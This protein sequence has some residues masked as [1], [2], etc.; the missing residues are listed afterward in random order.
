MRKSKRER[1]KL[2]RN[3]ILCIALVGLVGYAIYHFYKKKCMAEEHSFNVTQILVPK[4]GML[5]QGSARLCWD[6]SGVAMLEAE[7]IRKGIKDVDLSEAFIA[8]YNSL[9]FAMKAVEDKDVLW[10]L[11]GCM[12]DVWYCLDKYG[13]VP[14]SAMPY[15]DDANYNL[16]NAELSGGKGL[17]HQ[18]QL[19]IKNGDSEGNKICRQNI[20]AAHK[21]CFDVPPATFEF[22]GDTFTPQQFAHHLGL[23]GEDYV[24]VAST[25]DAPFYGWVTPQY[26]DH[27]RKVP[28]WNVP[29]DTMMALVDNSLANGYTVAWDGDISEHSFQWHFE[30]GFA[31]LSGKNERMISPRARQLAMKLGLTTD[32]HTMLICGKA[33]DENGQEYYVMKNSW[34]KLLPNG[35][36]MFVSRGYL[37]AKTLMITLNREMIPGLSK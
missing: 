8:Y 18:T 31:R 15:P 6:Y 32:D 35:G 9:E 37:R 12:A 4:K 23:R 25:S 30:Q 29:L 28:S 26:R 7:L 21:R 34:G 14:E 5:D 16:L 17:I 20:Y 22:Q 10:S 27:W 1:R 19:A 33:V 24:Q 11:G 3:I 13:I 36:M 2:I